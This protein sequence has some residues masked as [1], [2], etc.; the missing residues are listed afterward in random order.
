M[1]EIRRILAAT[2]FSACAATALEF[3]C[4]LASRFGAELHILHVQKDAIPY[5]GYEMECPEELRQQ[6][7]AL[8]GTAWQQTAEGDAVRACRPARLGNRDRGPGCECGH[9]CL[10]GAGQERDQAAD[11]GGSGRTC[12]AFGS[13]SGADVPPPARSRTT[14]KPPASRTPQ[15]TTKR[16]RC[17]APRCCVPTSVPAPPR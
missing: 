2:D 15:P 10:G 4:E 16:R 5:H 8:P 9:D 1:L 14:T 3:A 17:A 12:R 13:L 11:P 6:L 7:D